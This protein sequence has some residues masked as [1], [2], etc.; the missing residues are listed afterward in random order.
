MKVLTIYMTD[1]H[2]HT[3]GFLD[4]ENPANKLEKPI[5]VWSNSDGFEN[6][7]ELALDLGYKVENISLGRD[8]FEEKF[9]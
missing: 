2:D 7:S 5:Q 6:A 9:A 1:A 4:Y 8:D 3:V